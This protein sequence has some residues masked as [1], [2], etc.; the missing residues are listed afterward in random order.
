VTL[1]RAGPVP[2]AAIR[3]S[4]PSAAATRALGVQL[5]EGARPGDVIAL[6]GD[7]GAGKTCLIQGLAEGLEVATTVTSPTFVLIA[8]YPG[9]L[10]L[11][12]VDLYRLES[13]AEIR[14]LGLEELVDGEWSD[15]VT[16]IEWAER[17]VALLPERTVHLQIEGVGDEART[18]LIEGLPPDRALA[19][20]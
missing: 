11:R 9:R 14:A 5:G 16:A 1:D 19:F 12:H 8:E 6:R 15:G 20:G 7:L 2:S 17:A 3:L 13:L 4:C 18:I 10:P